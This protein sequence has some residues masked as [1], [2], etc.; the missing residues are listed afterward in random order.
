MWTHITCNTQKNITSDNYLSNNFSWVWLLKNILSHCLL[1][2]CCVFV[3]A[4]MFKIHNNLI[5]GMIGSTAMRPFLAHACVC[6]CMGHWYGLKL[7]AD[8]LS[9]WRVS[10]GGCIQPLPWRYR[11][12][13]QPTQAPSDLYPAP[14]PR[15]GLQRWP[16]EFLDRCHVTSAGPPTHTDQFKECHSK[17]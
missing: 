9:L 7:G 13:M 11:P 12:Q 14:L 15:S 17:A 1:Q 5:L 8:H 3:Y 2:Y 16:S 10:E 6:T 4:F